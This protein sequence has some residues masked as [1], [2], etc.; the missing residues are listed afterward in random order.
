MDWAGNQTDATYVYVL[1]YSS[2]TNPPVVQLYWPTNGAVVSGGSFTWRG[3]VEDPTVTVSAQIVD[4]SGD[5]NVMPG[6]V[7]RNGNFW[8]EDVP[9]AAGTS[10]LTLTAIDACTNMSVTSITV[11]QSSV[12]LSINANSVSGITIQ[13]TITVTGTIDTGGYSVWVNGVLASQ[14]GTSWTANNVPINGTGTAVIQARAIPNSQTNGASGG[15]GGTNCTLQ[16][17]GNPIPSGLYC[18]AEA[19]PDKLP[20]IIY[21]T[22]HRNT[23]TT[24]DTYMLAWNGWA[25]R[26]T[27]SEDW[28][29][30]V[31][32]QNLETGWKVENSGAYGSGAG[33]GFGWKSTVWD[34][35]TRIGTLTEGSS[36]SID[37]YTQIY[38][39]ETSPYL[40]LST[41]TGSASD[42][43]AADY[44]GTSTAFDWDWWDSP[45]YD[46][47][48]FSDHCMTLW[49][50]CPMARRCRGSVL[51]LLQ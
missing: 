26:S 16:S 7:E 47:G 32:G 8:V 20:V 9:L 28:S 34:D 45:D 36:T 46:S 22:Y 18:D 43:W 31:G 23:S 41:F 38:S 13:P 5:T 2:K 39:S 15:G 24:N 10:S 35:A 11:A 50:T 1:D 29:V 30:G 44:D 42:G 3:S 48:T 19:A 51:W 17:P 49:L 21:T 6:I 33:W 14:S 25:S 4:S 40:Y 37:D 27:Y 12:G